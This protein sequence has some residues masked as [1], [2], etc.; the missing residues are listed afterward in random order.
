MNAIPASPEPEAPADWIVQARGL[1]RR[2]GDLP[3]LDGMDLDLRR[4]EFVAVLGPSG[5]GKTTLIRIL[6]GLDTEYAGTVRYQFQDPSPNGRLSLAFQHAGLFPWHTLLDNLVLCLPAGGPGRRE[7]TGAAEHFL[8]L[9]GLGDFKNYYPHEISG[10]MQQRLN[11]ARAFACGRELLL[12]DEPFVFVDFIQRRHLQELTLQLLG[13][14]NRTIFFITHN[15]FEALNLADRILIMAAAPSRVLAQI[16]VPFPRTRKI[17]ECRTDS[18]FRPL[19]EKIES[20]LEGEVAKSQTRLE[21]CIRG[22]RP[23]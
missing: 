9:V 1:C 7:K 20:L 16:Q 2:F 12:M 18:Q 17:D 10:G 11:V 14:E 13:R 8:S 19:V 15:M 3:V 21:Q 23:C 22:L 5:C 6:A 4:G